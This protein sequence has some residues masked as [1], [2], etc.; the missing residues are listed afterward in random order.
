MQDHFGCGE[1]QVALK[2]NNLTLAAVGAQ[3]LSF[4]GRANTLRVHLSRRELQ[5]DHGLAR[6]RRVEQM[7]VEKTREVIA[8][9][10][11]ANAVAANIKRRR[12]HANAQLTGQNRDDTAGNPALGGHTDSI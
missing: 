8:H 2:L 4:S 6:V 7:Q 3:R 11:A 5:P 10:K 1:N 12:K 9:S